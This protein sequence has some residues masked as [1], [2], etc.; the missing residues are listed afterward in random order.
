MQ[1]AS[2]GAQF[3]VSIGLALFIGIEAD[4]WL[5][6]SFPLLAWLLPLLVIIAVIY[7]ILKDTSNKK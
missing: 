4:R 3:L 5:H 6:I 2:L 1:Y 7:K